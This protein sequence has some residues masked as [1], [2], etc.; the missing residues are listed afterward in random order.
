MVCPE[1]VARRGRAVGQ[2]M[3]SPSCWAYGLFLAGFTGWYRGHPWDLYREKLLA[4][5]LVAGAASA[6]LLGFVAVSRIGVPRRSRAGLFGATMTVYLMTA[7]FG[8]CLGAVGD[9][10]FGNGG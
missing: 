9:L 5:S 7:C 3:W 8:W 1:V 6:L 4:R 10:S 2:N